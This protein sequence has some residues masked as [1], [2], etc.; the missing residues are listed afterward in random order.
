MLKYDFHIHSKY[1]RDCKTPLKDILRAAKN[2]NL[3]GIAICDHDE[4]K[5]ALKA[6]EIVKGNPEKYGNLV[7]LPGTEV[8]TT[9]GHV[10][11]LGVTEIIPSFMTP[12]ETTDYARD[13]NAV[14]I[15]AH[16][17]RKSA[18][19]IGYLEG[20][21]ADAAETFNS[22]CIMNGSNKKARAE[23]ERIGMPQVG[24][25]DAHIAELVGQGYTLVNIE[26]NTPENVFDAILR[27]KTVPA[28]ENT[29]KGI[30]I[31]QMKKNVVRRTRMILSGKLKEC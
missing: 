12:E 31:N 28:G 17:F 20:S 18:H 21:G 27:G 14:S 10:L 2:R 9:K 15:I 7:V 5:G 23:A 22:K 13:L 25:S 1:S 8:S 11:V 3:D 26:V 29:P 6:L 24:G 19:G 16:P 30:V 4:V